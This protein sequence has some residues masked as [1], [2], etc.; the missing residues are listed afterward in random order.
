MVGMSSESGHNVDC[1]VW[2]ILNIWLKSNRLEIMPK[3]HQ[4]VFLTN[5]FD[6]LNISIMIFKN[7]F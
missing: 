5:M 3:P 4:N 1:V 6:S 7:R 2:S